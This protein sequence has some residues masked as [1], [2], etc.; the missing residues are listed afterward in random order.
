MP[1][2]AARRY[3]YLDPRAVAKL[4]SVSLVARGVVEGFVTGL[5]RSPHH[6]F[7][8]EFSEHRPYS[9]GDEIR[10]IDW[11]SYARSDRFTVKLFE[12]ET[13]VRCYVL[14]DRSASMG[15]GSE[16]RTKLEYAASLAGCLAYLMVRQQD[17]VGLVSFG[18]EVERYIPPRSTPTHLRVILEEL[19]RLKAA[20]PTEVARTFH[21]LAE[22]MKRRSLVVILSDLMDDE[23]EVMR[24]LHHFRRRKHEVILFHVLDPAELRFPFSRLAD[25]TDMETGER[26]Q[27]D[28]RYAREAY[29]EELGEF[30]RRFR[31]ECSK[32]LVEY[33]PV[34]TSTPYEVMLTAYLARR[35]GR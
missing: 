15:Y 24:A 29:L 13:N 19:E 25:F 2:E 16:G 8:V 31:R 14:L 30:V 3:R 18:R 21:D 10:R 20:G 4:G 7:S 28:P 26:I 34:D 22:S 6:G 1:P 9:P 11:K 27:V 17:S 33:V 35:G 23:S 32:T 5:H 12:N